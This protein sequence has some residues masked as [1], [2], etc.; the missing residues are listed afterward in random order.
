MSRTTLPENFERN[1]MIRTNR[2]YWDGVADRE[3]KR[4]GPIWGKTAVHRCAHPFDQK[5]GKGYWI[6]FYN[7]TP[8]KGAVVAPST[9]LAE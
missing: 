7:E 2:G 5:Y 1:P 9:K 6:G 8:P 3:R 4:T